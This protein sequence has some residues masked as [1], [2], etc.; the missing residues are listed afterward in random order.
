M[1]SCRRASKVY[2]DRTL[3]D[4][5]AVQAHLNADHFAALMPKIRECVHEKFSA[6]R[7]TRVE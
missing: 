5:A 2:P 7:L 6:M 3:T 4:Q 1:V